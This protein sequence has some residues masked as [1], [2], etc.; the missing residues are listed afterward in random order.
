[1][2]RQ[3]GDIGL[4]KFTVLARRK[5]WSEDFIRDVE[6]DFVPAAGN[7]IIIRTGAPLLRKIESLDSYTSKVINSKRKHTVYPYEIIKL[8]TAD[9]SSV[10]GILS[11]S[12]EEY[13][14]EYENG[15]ESQ[16][17]VSVRGREPGLNFS[18]IVFGIINNVLSK[19]GCSVRRVLILS[20]AARDMGSLAEEESRR[21]SAALELAE[22]ENIPVE[23][24][25][26]SSGARIDMKSGTE[27]LDWTA[28]VLRKIIKF[29]QSGG[30]INIIVSAANVGRSHTGMLNQQCLCIQ[31]VF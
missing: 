20:D 11:G 12:F 13:D 22:K 31:K 14:I 7:Q 2:M 6:F 25:P 3:A 4:E 18:N 15:S 19:T 24:I 1:M 9:A 30:E 16:K 10:S 27:N 23:W 26:V 17:A 29:T 5:R 8:L 28:V 21:I